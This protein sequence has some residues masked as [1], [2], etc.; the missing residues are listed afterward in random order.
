MF[1]NVIKQAE[2]RKKKAYSSCNVVRR[3]LLACKHDKLD[4]T[5]LSNPFHD[6]MSCLLF[7]ALYLNYSGFREM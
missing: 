1:I 3:N 5:L 6:D 2:E 4:G 7:L